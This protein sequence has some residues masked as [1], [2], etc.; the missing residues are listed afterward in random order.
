MVVFKTPDRSHACGSHIHI[1][2][3]THREW[4]NDELRDVAAGIAYYESYLHELI[5]A[6][7]RNNQYCQR[8]TISSSR[9]RAYRPQSGGAWDRLLPV[10]RSATKAEI[11]SLMQGDR[12]VLWNFAN[13]VHG[14]KGTIEFRGGRHLR[15]PV[16]TKRWIAFVIAYIH[17]LLREASIP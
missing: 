5:P 4:S 7:R 2:P 11:V 9:L 14:G 16:R 3:G 17:L 1:S 12:K 6:T 8:N 10:L 13:V 15:G